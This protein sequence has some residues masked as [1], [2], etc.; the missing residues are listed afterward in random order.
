MLKLLISGILFI[1]ISTSLLIPLVAQNNINNIEVLSNYSEESK[2]PKEVY[3]SGASS[4]YPKSSKTSATRLR[5]P[6]FDNFTY[7]TQ[8]D[9]QK[10]QVY[11]KVRIKK[12]SAIDPPDYGTAVLDGL[13]EKGRPYSTFPIRGYA[14]TLR[15]QPITLAGLSV[16]DSIRISFFFQRGGLC[17]KPGIEDTLF[18]DVIININTQKDSV[19][20]HKKFAFDENDN[21]TRFNYF[22]YLI[23]DSL[24]F[25]PRNTFQIQF[26]NFGKKSGYY[27]IWHI[28]QVYINARR[29]WQDT[30]FID[31]AIKGI[32]RCKEQPFSAIPY[33]L[34]PDSLYPFPCDTL[35]LRTGKKS[36]YSTDSIISR[37]SLQFPVNTLLSEKMTNIE[38]SPFSTYR[39][40][41]A[42]KETFYVNQINSI[43][44]LHHVLPN[45]DINGSAADLNLINI[46][47]NDSLLSYFRA[48]SIWSYDD[49]EP[50][51]GY[52]LRRSAGFGQKFSLDYP[53][54]TPAQKALAPDSLW[55]HSICLQ[56]L[57]IERQPR[58]LMIA[59]WLYK[60]KKRTYSDTSFI[61][62]PSQV[63]ART[64]YD[65]CYQLRNFDNQPRPLLLLKDHAYLVGVVQLTDTLLGV[66]YDMNN[67]NNTNVYWNNFGVW[68]PS[69]LGG[70]LAIRPVLSPSRQPITNTSPLQGAFSKA[71][72][73]PNPV[74]EN[75][76]YIAEPTLST[77]IQT[78]ELYIFNSQG[79][80]IFCNQYKAPSFPLA[81]PIHQPKGYYYV[82][83]RYYDILNQ[84]YTQT[85]KI[86]IP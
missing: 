67:N 27:D 11:Q 28:D 41:T 79:K 20:F 34:L 42:P 66:A 81:V 63:V 15:S 73:Y 44:A 84:A 2:M 61:I 54:L 77:P 64:N 48:D 8:P 13:N 72:L 60:D 16:K 9:P 22:S 83:F 36:I 75:V 4:I 21:G 59:V 31:R 14:D 6:F 10:W 38:I 5:L 80:E 37:F 68:V 43:K 26:S 33:F 32:K 71:L 52:G 24:F 85:F 47:T 19:F 7:G 18:F 69:Q 46:N 40:S 53:Q 12:F 82:Q 74:E 17:D 23:Q 30:F 29:N 57:P 49:F 78:V 45:R 76:F 3:R 25:N 56:F 62:H 70:T 86:I 50:E 35:L 39:I 1:S 55:M 65:T 51:L 58:R